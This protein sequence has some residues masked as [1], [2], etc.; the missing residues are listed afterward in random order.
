MSRVAVFLVLSTFQAPLTKPSIRNVA[1]T[2]AAERKTFLR[3]SSGTDD[4]AASTWESTRLS[5]SGTK[6]AGATVSP[7][8][9][10][11]PGTSKQLV[12]A[13]RREMVR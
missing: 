11:A 1:L 7:K 10:G 3:C 8:G 4:A 13:S 2:L 12:A 5:K 6:R 9:H